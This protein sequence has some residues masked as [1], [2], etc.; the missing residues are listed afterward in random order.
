MGEGERTSLAGYAVFLWLNFVGA[1]FYVDLC[2]TLC[3][4]FS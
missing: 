1:E 2:L 4:S 3:L